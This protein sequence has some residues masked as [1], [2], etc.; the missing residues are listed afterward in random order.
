MNEKGQEIT[1]KGEN[2]REEEKRF[3]ESINESV[4]GGQNAEYLINMYLN[5]HPCA[6]VWLQSTIK[7]N[8]GFYV[9]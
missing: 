8:S 1:S 3:E 5:F 4:E 2:K 6:F 7:S 9:R